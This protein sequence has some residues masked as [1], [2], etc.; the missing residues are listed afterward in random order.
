MRLATG[1][2]WAQPGRAY[3]GVEG[4]AAIADSPFASRARPGRLNPGPVLQR[5]AVPRG[6][7][8]S[9]KELRA[10]VVKPQRGG[11]Q[12]IVQHPPGYYWLAAVAVK[13]TG[14]DDQRW[15]RAVAVMRLVSVLLLTPLPLLAWAA[16]SRLLDDSRAALAAA[17]VP[18]GIPEL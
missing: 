2:G 5:D 1:Q 8:P 13:I 10:Q 17:V 14:G 18:L 16:A 4:Q 15:D 12:Q 11:I 6:D 9:W 3:V 7:R